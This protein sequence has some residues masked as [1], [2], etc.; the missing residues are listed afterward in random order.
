MTSVVMLNVVVLNVVAPSSTSLNIHF[1]VK[2][3]KGWKNAL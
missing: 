2:Y 3:L 1:R